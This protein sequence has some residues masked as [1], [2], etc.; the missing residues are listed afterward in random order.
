MDGETG[1]VSDVCDYNVSASHAGDI[2]RPSNGGIVHGKLSLDI[3]G[4]RSAHNAE[5]LQLSTTVAKE[6]ND[7]SH[8]KVRNIQLFLY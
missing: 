7:S 4:S 3:T 5:K 1:Y 6:A 2:I 8:T